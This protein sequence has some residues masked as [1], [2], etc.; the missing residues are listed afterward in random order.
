MQSYSYIVDVFHQ[1]FN[2]IEVILSWFQNIPNVFSF[3]Y[4]FE[5]RLSSL[6]FLLLLVYIVIWV[7][8]IQAS[9]LQIDRVLDKTKFFVI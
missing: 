9:F 4:L 5:F 3:L 2:C 6:D 8:A 1:I 7:F